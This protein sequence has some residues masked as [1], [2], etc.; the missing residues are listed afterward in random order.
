MNDESLMLGLERG[1]LDYTVPANADR[2]PQFISNDPSRGEKVITTM[3]EEMRNC[4]SSCS[5]SHSSHTT[6]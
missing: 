6:V 2:I 1:F 5:P 3:R 4:D